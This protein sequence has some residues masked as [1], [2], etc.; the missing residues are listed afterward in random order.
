MRTGF[1][2]SVI[3]A[4]ETTALR[5]LLPPPSDL[6]SGLRAGPW[7]WKV[8][9]IGWTVTLPD[10]LMAIALTSGNPDFTGQLTIGYVLGET[11]TPVFSS[12]Y[13]FFL[14]HLT[15]FT[16]PSYN[17]PFTLPDGASLASR[18]VK[19]TASPLVAWPIGVVFTINGEAESDAA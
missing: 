7:R 16:F 2:V 18:F 3:G 13:W 14:C 8:T 6:A 5:E 11:F 17:L 10:D 4:T 9:S 12:I 1:R 19:G 15:P